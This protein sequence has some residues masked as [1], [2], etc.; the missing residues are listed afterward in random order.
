MEPREHKEARVAWEQAEATRNK[1]RKVTA[2]SLWNYAQTVA[3]AS[4]MAQEA[5]EAYYR[6]KW[7][8]SP[9]SSVG[10]KFEQAFRTRESL[11]SKLNYARGRGQHAKIP[12]LMKALD[13]AERVFTAARLDPVNEKAVARYRQYNVK[14]AKS[15]EPRKPRERK[16][17]SKEQV[18]VSP[19]RS[20]TP[21]STPSAELPTNSGSIGTLTLASPDSPSHSLP[22]AAT[23]DALFHDMNEH[24]LW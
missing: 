10:T 16:Q 8:A 14:K 3:H 23:M 9:L 12:D 17:R 24:G 20:Q 21:A 19:E 15:Q 2:S 4:R 13:E 18:A 6:L 11:R 1:L 5:G 7:E 22:D